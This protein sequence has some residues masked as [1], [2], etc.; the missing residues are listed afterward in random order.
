[1]NDSM[2]GNKYKKEIREFE[3]KGDYTFEDLMDL[4]NKKCALRAE[5]LNLDFDEEEVAKV[6]KAKLK[7]YFPRKASIKITFNPYPQC[8]IKT[9]KL[10]F[11]MLNELKEEFNLKDIRIKKGL[12]KFK[13]EL[14][15]W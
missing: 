5:I 14:V 1:M 7:G 13:V 15:L 3:N 2:F 4:H 8:F 6:L 10:D 12:R 11:N 9:R